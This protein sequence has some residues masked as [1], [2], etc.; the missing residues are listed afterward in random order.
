MLDISVEGQQRTV[1]PVNKEL[2]FRSQKVSDAF[3]QLSNI[4]WNSHNIRTLTISKGAVLTI[5]FYMGVAAEQKIR[6]SGG[7]S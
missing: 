1:I 3:Y 5:L 2:L 6:Y 4:L 7:F